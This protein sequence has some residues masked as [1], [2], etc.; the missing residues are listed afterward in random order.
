M[1]Y[2][3]SYV[4]PSSGSVPSSPSL[5]P[6]PSVSQPSSTNTTSSII[7]DF[8]STSG[9]STELSGVNLTKILNNDNLV[10]FNKEGDYLNLKQN[11]LSGVFEGDLLFHENS[12]DTF[13]TY[14]LYMMERIA[15]FD[16]ELP[17]ELTTRKFQLFNEKGLHL[18]GSKY[19]L[20]KV[21][22]IEPVNND[23]NFS[24]KWIYGNSFEV[25][26]PIGTIIKFDT[27]IFE[28][29]DPNR[30]YTVV[31]SK[32]NAIM[33]VSQM[34]NSTFDVNYFPDYDDLELYNNI[35]ISGINALGVYDYID[36]NYASNLSSW[37]EQDFYDLYYTGKK[38]SIINSDLNDG[39]ITVE[40]SQL[41]D[42]VH[43]EYFLNVDDLPQDSNLIIEVVTK[44]DVPKIFSGNLVITNN[45]II[46]NNYP[47]ILKPGIVFKIIGSLNN[48]NFVT[49]APIS[50]W[51]G[52]VNETFFDIGSQV[53]FENN[54]YEC[55]QSY[56]Q[57]FGDINTSFINPLIEDFW[58][59]PTYIGVEELMF[60]ETINAQLYLTSDRYYFEYQA[61]SSSL[62]TLSSSVERFKDDLSIFN[63][64]LFFNKGLRADLIYPSNYAE[65]NFY[66][67]NL[68]NSIGGS[69]QTFERLVGV[70]ES[71]NYE[72]NY[73][74]S[75]N[76]RYNIVITDIDRL[77]LKITI[78]GMIYDVEASIVFTGAV[79]DMER[80]I[81]RT[82]RD[83]LKRHY[84]TL[85]RLGIDT[86]L[87]YS[88][89]YNS[90]FY[91]SLLITSQYPNV[92][93]VLNEILVG[94]TADF[95]VEHS[96]VN[97]N[98]IGPYFNI[99]INDTD[100]GVESIY[101]NDFDVDI[102]GT[103]SKWVSEWFDTLSRFSIF[104]KSIS[105]RI[106]FTIKRLDRRLNYTINT[107]LLSLPGIKDFEINKKLFGNH[108]MLVTSNE[109][110]LP[111]SS[112]E[113]FISQG[114]STGMIFSINNTIWSFV[115]VEYNILYLDDNSL[116]LSYEGPFFGLT[117]SI[118]NSSAFVTL[119]FDLGFNYEDCPEPP[120]LPNPG[121]F[122]QFEF[123][124]DFSISFNLNTY[125][126]NQYDL[127][128][129]QG[130][131][132]LIDLKY[133]Q[134]SSCLYGFGDNLVVLDA[135][136][137]R[138]IKTIELT[139]N[140]ESI[141]MDFNTNS[142][143]IYLLS[144]NNIWIVDPITNKLL[145]NVSLTHNA[146][147]ISVNSNNGDV[148]VSYSNN[149]K[150]DIWSVSNFTNTPTY[151]I[152]NSKDLWPSN[153][154]TAT[155]KMIFNDFEGDM[156]II[157]NDDYVL[158][159]NTTRDIQTTY[160]IDNLRLDTI[161]Y[162]PINESIYIYGDNLFK[163]DNN[164][165]FSI[166]GIQSATFSNLIFNN[167][168]GQ[169][170]ISDS[171]NKF[172]RLNL[173]DSFLAYNI[174]DFGPLAINQFDGD[175]Y[176][177]SQ[178]SN[179]IVVIRN[180]VWIH[181]EE[182]SESTTKIIYNPERKSIW[183]IQPSI[184]SLVEI[185]VTLG[186]TIDVLISSTSV[187]DNAYGTLDDNYVE[188]P[189]MWLKTRDFVR[190]PRENFEGGVRV[191]YYWKW[192]T[193]NKPEFFMY[194]F[195]G[196]QLHKN[197]P[198][199]YTGSRPLTEIV[200]NRKENRNLDYVNK[201]EFQ[202][203]VFDKIEYNL[204]YLND[205]E[206]VTNEVEPIQ[207][208][209][210]F[211]SDNEGAFSSTLQLFKKEEIIFDIDSDSN[212]SI[213]LKTEELNG[214]R[215]GTITINTLSNEIFTDKGLKPGQRIVIYLK[216]LTN[217]INQYTSDNTASVFI[218]R[219][220]FT[221]MLVLDFV[222]STDFIS[223][224]DTVINDYPSNDNTTYLRFSLKVA[225]K[226]LCR[227]NVMGQTEEE[228]E[229]FKIELGNLGKLINPDEV[230]I[231]K[232]YDIL[233]G[234]IDWTILNKKRK[235]MLMMKHL[236]YPYIGAYKSI[237]NAI[238]YFGYN[239]LQL[240]EYYRNIDSNSENFFKLFKVEISNIFDNSIPGWEE[241]DFIK[242]TYPN[243]NFEETNLFNLTYEITDKGG[244]TVLNYSLDEIIIKLQ[245]LK[246]WLKRNIIPL[247]HK[248]MDITGNAYF[249]TSSSIQHKV[250]DIRII[251]I[252]QEMSPISFKLNEA[253]LMPV[254]SGSTVYNCVLDFYS[255]VP[256]VGTEIFYL[257]DEIKPFNDS[258]LELP[259]YFNVKVRT[260]K[261]YKEWLPFTTYSIGEKIIYFEKLYES[262]IDNNR[263]KN[264]RRYD[265]SIDWSANIVY[266]VATIVR[267]D[268]D[269]YVF[270][271]L[272][273]S[274]STVSPNIDKL[275]WL[276][277]T[278]WKEI[279]KEPVQTIT[280]FRTSDNLLPFNFTVDSN[281]DPFITI[282]VTS[283]NGYGQIYNDRKN[284][285]IRGT[286]NLV[287]DDVVFD[288]IG[289]FEPIVPVLEQFSCNLTAGYCYLQ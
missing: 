61:A 86:E 80:S 210:G 184:N 117:D 282:E 255:I 39:V 149:G 125:D 78:N 206:D 62:V 57:S 276:K 79:I 221:K 217:T 103:L 164:N 207:L 40:N 251:N 120:V 157:T 45:K 122:N 12:N 246:Y 64:D 146:Y 258:I 73:N 213:S 265:D 248:I 5:S 173:D 30:T 141:K 203:T 137:G 204:S 279:D 1:P 105:N 235:E 13:K 229:R 199:A 260:Y 110:I 155:G 32:T 240:N 280:E 268:R 188:R 247:T 24:S 156:Y 215:F 145:H 3:S 278:E 17:G 234:G 94:T 27:S 195:S 102:P 269:Y 224:E 34:D 177:S 227:F 114:F 236:I 138:Y 11:T 2:H 98:N 106:I 128:I 22:K 8:D 181:Q 134:L 241:N 228:D 71:I 140:T 123:S 171:S 212:T 52:I 167:V 166:N 143:L 254:N 168:N 197:G 18:Y 174:E 14:G 70:S 100:Y 226:E 89:S 56:T 81:D 130:T 239:D 132:N 82:L 191:K 67:D 272:G 124:N 223:Q 200:L 49:V 270:S 48:T 21:I 133:V 233:E 263:I 83:W 285:E 160:Q 257:S 7:P 185:E 136:S 286:K 135:F 170:N 183:A 104:V 186:S 76:W 162:E 219:Q 220:V 144:S 256:N 68:N 28:F 26:F 95:Y 46:L 175:V 53:I 77:G 108:G 205:F 277:V 243:N 84:I 238:N 216:D 42:Q 15:S 283:D 208:F 29:V 178:I 63:I 50:E 151:T 289:P 107:G 9:A 99:N 92:S 152:N 38:I 60:N 214:D 192:L 147:D 139:G 31:S 259:D 109:V 211:K 242:N 19:K 74:F 51:N 281:L 20:Q 287:S 88:G 16:F 209:L 172:T 180:G 66:Y 284:Y 75:E 54:I 182:L 111:S 115:N 118:C 116:N 91:N 112:S 158:R 249:N 231:F 65:V 69:K 154:I 267:Y 55:I 129:F 275:N 126:A 96:D 43:I 264:P 202:Q 169:I 10:F 273:L 187:D 58:G 189:S 193:D 196:D 245:G 250:H 37:N 288:K 222:K 4:P 153:N 179:K 150:V 36:D 218:I 101:I 230:F 271:G 194:D 121:S 93:L 113:S 35:N 148:Y 85:Y 87:K 198:Y 274:G 47:K 41:T 44:T 201:P 232:K 262:V 59:A 190:R 6:S 23:P 97:F 176:L 131:G 244:N 237:I 161:H 266:K 25:K 72:L 159:V 165:S 253:Y 127:D 33:I 163:I 225:D 90:V 142:D 261:T 119:A 252:K